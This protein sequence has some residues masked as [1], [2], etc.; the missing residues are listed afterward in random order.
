MRNIAR[1]AGCHIYSDAGDVVYASRNFLGIYA[2]AGGSRNVRLP[3]KSRVIDLLE[4]RV[5]ADGVT[6]FEL[7]L[8]PNQ[9]VLLRIDEDLVPASQR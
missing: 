8:E 4:N 5:L 3:R 1:A 2:P 6:S 9:S 7:K